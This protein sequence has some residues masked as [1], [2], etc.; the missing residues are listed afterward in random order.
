MFETSNGF[1]VDI[2]HAPR[3][4]QED[5]YDA[6]MIP[7]IPADRESIEPNKDKCEDIKV[8][9]VYEKKKREYVVIEG[10]VTLFDE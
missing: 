1:I 8:K 3:D 6:G 7:Y 9:P 10:Q 2:R 5:L 4:I